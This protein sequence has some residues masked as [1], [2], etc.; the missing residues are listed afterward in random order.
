MSG[1]GRS[2]FD[3][4]DVGVDRG[5]STRPWVT[6]RMGALMEAGPH[7]AAEEAG[8]GAH[9]DQLVEGDGVTGMGGG[10]LQAMSA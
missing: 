6:S 1:Q 2:E 8:P 9:A 3:G 10:S 7:D 4:E 5:A